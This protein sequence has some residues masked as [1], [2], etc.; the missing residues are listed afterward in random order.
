VFIKAVSIA[1]H[2]SPDLVSTLSASDNCVGAVA[3][4]LAKGGDY[5]GTIFGR[6]T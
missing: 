6:H 3:Y 2:Q 1:E 4:Y 5:D